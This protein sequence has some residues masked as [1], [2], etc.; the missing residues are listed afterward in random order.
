VHSSSHEAST[1]VERLDPALMHMR[2]FNHREAALAIH[3]V[4]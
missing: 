3:Q 4:T 1:V 2:W